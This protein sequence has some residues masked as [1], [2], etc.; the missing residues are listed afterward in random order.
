VTVWDPMKHHISQDRSAD[1]EGR[2]RHALSERWGKTHALDGF[3]YPE[4]NDSDSDEYEDC[5]DRDYIDDDCLSQF[6]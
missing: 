3:S 2:L 6:D 5:G 4:P 1:L